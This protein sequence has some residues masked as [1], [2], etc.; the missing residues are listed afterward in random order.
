MARR[1]LPGDRVTESGL[2]E[3][4]HVSKTPVREALLRL[5]AMG[6]VEPDGVRGGRV[7]AASGHAIRSAYEVRAALE[8]HAAYLAAERASDVA[9]A[10]IV[11]LAHTSL[12]AAVSHDVQEFRVQDRQF[13]LAIADSTGNQR[14]G[15]LIKDA[16]VLTWTLRMR[17]VPLADDSVECARQHDRIA[18]AIEQRDK[19]AA[20]QA[21]FQHLRTVWAIVAEAF[22]SDVV[23]AS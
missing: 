8:L 13:H 11:R 3:Q 12:E 19:P 10:A 16:V 4:L 6:L 5:Q 7:V 1:M 15:S 22:S 20:A 21:M 17:D 23:V 18:A 14:L 2:A 9:V